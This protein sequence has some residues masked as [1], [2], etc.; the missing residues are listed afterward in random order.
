[1]D[2]GGGR[3][4]GLMLGYLTLILHMTLFADIFRQTQGNGEPFYL[5]IHQVCLL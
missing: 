5:R 1:M 3:E 4:S 2:K